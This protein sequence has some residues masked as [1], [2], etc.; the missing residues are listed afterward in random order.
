[1]KTEYDDTIAASGGHYTTRALAAAESREYQLRIAKPNTELLVVVLE[2]IM[3]VPS[4]TATET[5]AQWTFLVSLLL[6]REYWQ[7]VENLS[8]MGAIGPEVNG[9]SRW[10]FEHHAM[11]SQFILAELAMPCLRDQLAKETAAD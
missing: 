11:W 5:A 9:V 1:L 7:A 4:P 3:A 10:Y 8:R 6:D 2:R